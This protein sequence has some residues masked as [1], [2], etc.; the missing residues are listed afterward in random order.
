[1]AKMI[2][3]HTTVVARL[4]RIRNLS[5]HIV[6]H[7]LY[8]S[9]VHCLYHPIYLRYYYAQRCMLCQILERWPPML[10]PCVPFWAKRRKIFR[11]IAAYLQKLWVTSNM[12]ILTQKLKRCKR[13]QPI[14]TPPF[15]S[16]TRLISNR[17]KRKAAWNFLHAA[18]LCMFRRIIYT[19]HINC[20]FALRATDSRG[21]LSLRCLPGMLHNTVGDGSPVP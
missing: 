6:I 11:I 19:F 12:I 3:Q 1:M 17:Y 21:R 13:L 5:P 7:K 2:E 9:V 20:T 15:H 8:I 10:N 4:L 14:R 18:F 16:C